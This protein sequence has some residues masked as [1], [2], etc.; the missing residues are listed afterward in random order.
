VAILRQSR[1]NWILDP[2]GVAKMQ[3]TPGCAPKFRYVDPHIMVD[4]ALM[5]PFSVTVRRLSK[6]TDVR[7]NSPTP[8]PSPPVCLSFASRVDTAITSKTPPA[9]QPVFLSMIC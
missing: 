1:L 8:V 4:S 2:H 6:G 7:I 5:L 9:S 3:S